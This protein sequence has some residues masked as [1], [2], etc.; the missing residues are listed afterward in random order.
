M[1]SVEPDYEPLAEIL[2][3]ALDQAGYIETREPAII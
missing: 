1:M 2:Q 3:E